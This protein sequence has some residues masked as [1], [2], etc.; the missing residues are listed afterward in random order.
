[1]QKN[2]D[3]SNLL[4]RDQ[5]NRNK[6]LR[7]EDFKNIPNPIFKIRRGIR[8]TKPYGLIY[9]DKNF[10]GS[11]RNVNRIRNIKS[12]EVLN[13]SSLF[14][15]FSFKNNRKISQLNRRIY[16]EKLLTDLSTFGNRPFMKIRTKKIKKGNHA[17]FLKNERV[18]LKHDNMNYYDSN[19][20]VDDLDQ[21]MYRIKDNKYIKET[22]HPI[23]KNKLEHR[24]ETFSEDYYLDSLE[25]ALRSLNKQEPKTLGNNYLPKMNFLDRT[26]K[27]NK[28]YPLNHKEIIRYDSIYNNILG[29]PRN[30]Y[31]CGGESLFEM[32]Q[33]TS[34]RS[35]GDKAFRKK[36]LNKLTVSC[37]IDITKEAKKE[38]NNYKN[39]LK[40]ECILDF[41]LSNVSKNDEQG[42]DNQTLKKILESPNDNKNSND[43]FDRPI[44]SLMN[45]NHKIQNK[46]FNCH[47]NKMNH[48]VLNMNRISHSQNSFSFIDADFLSKS[49]IYT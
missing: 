36:I 9:N 7:R 40:V 38:K 33:A 27:L 45:D 24:N 41:K 14:Y 23:N 49:T 16:E 43:D 32:N 5:I 39:H 26:K 35:P 4:I 19:E 42:R 44:G 8:L 12:S 3:I 13:E 2:L 10:Y 17:N 15:D 46:R 31:S 11:I 37:E 48:A 1:M 47:F 21:K 30:D 20:V 29:Y 28:T 6:Y 25:P 18:Y 34:L 22:I